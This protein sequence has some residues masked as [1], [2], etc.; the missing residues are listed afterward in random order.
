VQ[1]PRNAEA[2]KNLLWNLVT[3]K[4]RWGFSL[5]GWL[6]ILLCAICTG[7]L[8]GLA[9][10]PFL[11]VSHRVDT[12][13]LVVE[14]WVSDYTMVAAVKEFRT[15]SY[16]RVFTSGGPVRGLSHY[17]NDFQTSA[18]VGADLLV[19]AGLPSELVQMV[20]S[21]ITGRD[22]TYSSAVALREWF[23]EH[24]MSVHGIN[25]LTEDVHARRTRL[26][27]Q[28]AFRKSTSVG[29][30]AI[31]NPDYD[32]RRWWCYSE[33]VRDVIGETIAY[34]Y[35]RF[36]FYPSTLSERSTAVTSRKHLGDG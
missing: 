2:P 36:F 18:S 26:L 7:G 3:R 15:G 19:R 28:L 1:Q 12:K 9:L 20:P 4:E 30:I 10:Q 8:L 21:H 35:A 31:P 14:G 34:I 5:R 17:V 32:R 25:V 24:D 33:G 11:A 16:E 27:F 6:F 22:R 29:V 23:H 13:I